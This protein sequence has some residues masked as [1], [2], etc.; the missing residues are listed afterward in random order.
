MIVR[1]YPELRGCE[2]AV[3]RNKPNAKEVK[4]CDKEIY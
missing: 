1:D 3:F 4:C 2:A